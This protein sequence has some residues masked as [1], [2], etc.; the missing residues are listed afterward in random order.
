M[1]RQTAARVL[2]EGLGDELVVASL[3]TPSFDLFGAT[4]QRDLN[5]YVWS[6]MGLAASVGLGL[7]LAQPARQVIV[8]EG[9][10]SVLMNLNGLAT[11]GVRAPRNLTVLV[12]DDGLYKETG[13][14]QTAT[15]AGVDLAAVGRATLIE[16]SVAVTDPD[17]LRAV[18]QR[19][20]DGGGPHLIVAKVN[21]PGS[22]ARPPRDPLFVKHTF[23]RALGTEPKTLLRGRSADEA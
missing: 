18:L 9:D 7:A 5:F 23:M 13:N 21:G 10:G 20:R 19:A 12:L 16:S 11:I 1:D 6:A 8:L 17:G 2:A 4:G 3:G 15:G 22:T 14:Q